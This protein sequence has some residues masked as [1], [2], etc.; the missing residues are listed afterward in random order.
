MNLTADKQEIRSYLLGDL[1]DDRK[2]QLEERILYALEAYE[3]LL[4]A[5]EE[6]IDAYVAGGLSELERQRFE[7]HFLVTAERQKNLRFGQ[8]LNRYVNSHPFPVVAIPQIEK[9]APAKKSFMFSVLP[10]G[11]RPVM[12]F[13]VTLLSNKPRNWESPSEFCSLGGAV[14]FRRSML[15]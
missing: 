10:A 6:L 12:V 11:T 2:T 1:D 7:S 13:C 14:T 3:E 5:E 9:S 8:L 4:I 15:I